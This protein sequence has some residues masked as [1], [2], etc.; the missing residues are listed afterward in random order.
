VANGTSAAGQPPILD[1]GENRWAEA[2]RREAT[3]R[4]LAAREDTNRAEIRVAAQALGLSAAQLYRL[5]GAYRANPV[6]QSLVVKK[7]GPA[8]GH[9]LL[10]AAVE[11]VITDAIESVFMRR[12]RPTLAR[13]CRDI[14]TNCRGA[15]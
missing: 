5:L 14:R 2:V 1:I 6:T 4:S 10:P 15:G 11:V 7:P 12:E 13:L 3:V 8:K 9:R